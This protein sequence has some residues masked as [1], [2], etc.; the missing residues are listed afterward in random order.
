MVRSV[1]TQIKKEVNPGERNRYIKSITQHVWAICRW[2][3]GLYTT[4]PWERA[5]HRYTPWATIGGLLQAVRATQPSA[6]IP[7]FKRMDGLFPSLLLTSKCLNSSP[8]FTKKDPWVA[9]ETWLKNQ[10]TMKSKEWG[11][12]SRG[13][14]D[15]LLASLWCVCLC[16]NTST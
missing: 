15:L 12:Q 2:G 8:I 4:S 1:V 3:N 13:K 7:N 11:S 5:F 16:I 14:S 10:L 9:L 6:S